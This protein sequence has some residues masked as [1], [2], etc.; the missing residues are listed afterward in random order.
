MSASVE[1]ASARLSGRRQFAAIRA[2]RIRVRSG[3]LQFAGM[4][5]GLS[6]SRVGFAIVDVRSAVTRNR[7]RRRLREATRAPL[8]AHPGLDIVVRARA[9]SASRPFAGLLADV[10]AGIEELSG[11]IAARVQEAYKG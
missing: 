3:S 6:R 1:A 10:A 4:P 9:D 5:N 7:I 8:Q 11:R 2:F